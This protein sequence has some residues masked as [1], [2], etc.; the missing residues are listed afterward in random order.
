MTAGPQEISVP[1]LRLKACSVDEHARALIEMRR[2]PFW[3]YQGTSRIFGNYSIPFQDEA[4]RWWYQV[5]PG[6]CW[7]VDC[8]RPVRPDSVKM[9][10]GKACFGFQHVVENDTQANSHLVINAILD[11][12]SYGLGF[13]DRKKRSNVRRGLEHCE[14]SL[15]ESFDEVVFEGCRAAWNDLSTRTGW[16][17]RVDKAE[18]HESWKLLVSCAGVSVLVGRDRKSGQVAGFLITKII[19]DT[20]YV[21]TIA[22]RTDMLSLHINDAMMYSFLA[23]S[24]RL[25]GVGKAHC[26]IK[27]YVEPLER[28][29]VSLGFKPHPF[30]ARTRLKYGIELLMPLF[31]RSKYN[32]MI[33]RI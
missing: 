10:F 22:S 33:G 3:W 12:G 18:F 27:S 31:F 29:K 20:A 1:D 19:G 2:L 23:A 25:P 15:L 30:P 7:A 17:H 6:L 8:F 21:D 4:G 26:A 32:R 5:K 11:L 24:S 28:F 13:I 16:K 9:P 14:L